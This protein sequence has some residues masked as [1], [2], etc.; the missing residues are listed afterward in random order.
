MLDEWLAGITPGWEVV[1]GG[2]LAGLAPIYRGREGARERWDA[3]RGPWEG[4]ELHI[5]VERIEDLGDTVLALLTVWASGG[6]SGIP[7]AIKWAHVIAF[8][9]GDQHVR[10][11]ANWDEVPKAVGLTE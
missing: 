11:Y 3:L 2:A 6:S 4:Q 10:S 7:V 9:D 5:A 8:S 1:T